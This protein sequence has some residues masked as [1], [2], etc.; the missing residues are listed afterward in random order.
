MTSFKRN[1]IKEISQRHKDLAFGYLKQNENIHKSNYPQLIKYLI[2]VYSN[3]KDEFDPIITHRRLVIDGNYVSINRNSDSSISNLKNV[4]KKG[5]HIWRFK[6]HNSSDPVLGGTAAVG[7]RNNVSEWY[8]VRTNGT[9]SD[10]ETKLE[11]CKTAIDGDIIEMTLDFNKLTL[12][13]KLNEK[14]NTKF[15]DIEKGLYRAMIILTDK[16]QGFTLT[17]YHD[18]YD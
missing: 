16:G 4:V 17:S 5:V 7:I 2:L 9:K 12:T 11:R 6:Y 1:I 14:F 13:F 15:I 3:S 8:F 10:F 18:I